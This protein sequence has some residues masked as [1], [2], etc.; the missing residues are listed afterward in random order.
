V[1]DELHSDPPLK[2]SPLTWKP[3]RSGYDEVAGCI[4]LGRLLEKAR[5]AEDRGD[6]ALGSYLLGDRDYLDARLLSFLGLTELDVRRIVR[7][8]P[9]DNRAGQLVLRNAGKTTRD[10]AT[11]NRHF[12]R[13]F[14]ILLAMLDADEG[15]RKSSLGTKI[16]QVTNNALIF[17]IAR[18][19]YN[20]MRH[21]DEK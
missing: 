5:R 11:F 6:A 20:R 3:Q 13:R 9:D 7:C 1:I 12:V 16:M 17:P 21:G 19:I 8:E 14:G 4:W 15:R 18:I 10:C 2:E